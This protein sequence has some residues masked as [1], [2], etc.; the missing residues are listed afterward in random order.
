MLGF[1]ST[2]L[3]Q[4]SDTL[5]QGSANSGLRTKFGPRDLHLGYENIGIHIFTLTF[6]LDRIIAI[7]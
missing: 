4:K 7:I 6:L 1:I 2:V 3:I 5:H